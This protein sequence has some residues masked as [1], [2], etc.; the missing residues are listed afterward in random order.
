VVPDV[1]GEGGGGMSVTLDPGGRMTST[2]ENGPRAIETLVVLLPPGAVAPRVGSTRDTLLRSLIIGT[3]FDDE[4]TG[5]CPASEFFGCGP[6]LVD[7]ADWRRTTRVAS[8]KLI[9]RFPMPYK[10]TVAITF[11]NVGPT[12]ITPMVSLYSEPFDF[13]DRTLYFHAMWYCD[14][15]MQMRFFRDFDFVKIT[16]AGQYV[17]D[18]LTVVNP[19][20]AWWGEG[21]EKVFV[22]GE[23]FP[24]HFGT[25]SED[26]YGYAWGAT[27]LFATPFGGQPR[28]DGP[29]NFGTTTVTRSRLLDVIP[30]TKS[31]EY[32]LEVWNWADCD[33]SYSVGSFWYARPGATCNRMPQ[34]KEAAEILSG[35]TIP[36]ALEAEELKVAVRSDGLP[37]ETQTG[38]AFPA[39]RWSRDAQ[40]FVKGRQ[41]GDFVKLEVPPPPPQ[42]LAATLSD[43]PHLRI[44][45]TKSW[46]YGVLRFSSAG[47]PLGP[48]Y[49][50]FDAKGDLAKQKFGPVA[51]PSSAGQPPTAPIVLRIEVVGKNPAA[52]GSGCFFGI[53]ALEWVR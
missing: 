7:F 49:D 48:D 22:D 10:K 27:T 51:P 24:S 13:N 38:V 3:K 37:I 35:G 34:T 12:P 39:G 33:V 47:R 26:H 15:Y 20:R 19:A 17:G 9:A 4:T 53:D 21:D 46:D 52:K 31:L 42:S 44:T 1:V 23:P 29:A 18:T 11:L 40:L 16:G 50:A 36:G 8:G 41:I 2:L 6:R 5:W 25:G 14:H 43:P 45:L 30:F 32:D 28:V